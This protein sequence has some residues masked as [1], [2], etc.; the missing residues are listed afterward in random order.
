MR[1][2]VGK[3]IDNYISKLSNLEVSA[4]DAIGKAVYAGA[5]I[6]T[7]KIRQNIEALP[8]D[9][10][11]HKEYVTAPKSIQKKGLLG[12]RSKKNDGLGIAPIQNDRGYINV[13]VGFGGYNELKSKKYPKGQPNA[14]IARTFESGNSFTKKTPFVGPAIRATKDIAEM[15]MAQIIDEETSKIMNS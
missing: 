8:V 9:D 12:R 11:P 14:M 4:P 10:T 7:D 6:V 1:L 13:K 15:K 3:G 5:S 2:Q